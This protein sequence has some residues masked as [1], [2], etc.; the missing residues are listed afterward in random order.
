MAVWEKPNPPPNLGRRCLTHS[1]ETLLW[2]APPGRGRYYFA[3]DELRAE[4]GGKQLKTVWR[5]TAPGK[6][7]KARGGGHPTQKPE[8]LVERCIRTD[9]HATSSGARP[10][11]RRASACR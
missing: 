7:E 5:F 6:A 3:Y 4:N 2:L 9:G 1:H 8:A 11:G 10:S